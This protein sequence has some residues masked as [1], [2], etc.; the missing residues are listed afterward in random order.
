MY[1]NKGQQA[2]GKQVWPEGVVKISFFIWE[3]ESPVTYLT[4]VLISAGVHPG[5]PF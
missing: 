5:L 1:L 3:S 4:Q 2:Y